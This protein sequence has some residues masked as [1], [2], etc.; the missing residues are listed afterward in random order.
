[1]A[2]PNYSYGGFSINDGV[3]YIVTKKEFGVVP[4]QETLFKIARLPGMKKT[5]AIVNERRLTLPVKVIA[6]SRVALEQALDNLYA[7]LSVPQ[8]RL[9]LHA[10]DGRYYIADCVSATAP[11]G[12]GDVVST[13]ATLQ[14]L[15][16]QPFLYAAS[17]SQYGSGEL[18]TSLISGT[19]WQ[20]GSLSVASSGTVFAYPTITLTNNSSA[21]TNTLAEPATPAV[22]TTVSANT[23]VLATS[24]TVASTAGLTGT[25]TVTLDV[26]PGTGNQEAATFN[27]PATG[28][29]PYTLTV[30][31][32][33]N[34]GA[35]TKA[36][37][38]GDTIRSVTFT[39]STSYAQIP[40]AAGLPQ[41]VYAGQ[42]FVLTYV[43]PARGTQTQTVTI[44]TG[45]AAGATTLNVTTFTT[46]ASGNFPAGATSV[47]YASVNITGFTLTQNP[48]GMVLQ[49]LSL[50]TSFAPGTTITIDCDPTSANGF[51]VI[52]SWAP[53][54]PIAFNGM[55]PVVEPNTTTLNLQVIATTQPLVTVQLTWTPRWLS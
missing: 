27:L 42:Q 11:L 16:Q 20:T 50:G 53:N 22:N 43:D 55:F 30:A 12:P 41:A 54:T 24:I 1:M 49:V 46:S 45:A 5:G 35:L 2:L 38:S 3:T 36:H 31:S 17:Q 25:G 32:T 40:L 10:V 23:A 39:S 19:N 7:A 34:G 37:T 14:F 26:S 28:T 6:P 47:N 13:T 9:N 8:Q 18:A 51:T 15:C 52:G 29:G 21:S 33:Y 4:V 44:A 48:D